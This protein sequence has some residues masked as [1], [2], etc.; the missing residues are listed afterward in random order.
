MW[1]AS[2]SHAPPPSVLKRVPGR[3]RTETAAGGGGNVGTDP[4]AAVFHS[5]GHVGR[6]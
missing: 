6:C 1:D 2:V 4:L 3:G 5:W